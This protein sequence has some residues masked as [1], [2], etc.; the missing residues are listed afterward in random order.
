MLPD[1]AD[2][3]MQ[4]AIDHFTKHDITAAP[5]NTITQAEADPHPWERRVLVE[6]PDPI[7]GTISVSGDFWHFGRSEV[8]VGSTPT[9]GQHTE[10]LLTDLLGLTPDQISELREARVVV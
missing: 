1:L 9:V 5:V 3:T 6:V 10:E 7:A 2:L 8:V 4:Q